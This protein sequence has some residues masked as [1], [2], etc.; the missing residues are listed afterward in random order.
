[1]TM[2]WWGVIATS[3]LAFTLKYLGHSLPDRFLSNVRIQNINFFIPIALLSSLVA[4]QTMAE[5]G[6]VIIDHRLAGVIAALVLLLLKAPF[7]AV[8]LSSA[9]ISAFAYH[10]FNF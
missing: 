9:T 3:A 5:K 1:M 10:I 6:R 7:P 4:V 8:V 2:M